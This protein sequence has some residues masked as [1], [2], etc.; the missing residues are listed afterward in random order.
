MYDTVRAHPPRQET[1]QRCWTFGI[2]HA[3]HGDSRQRLAIE[4]PALLGTASV[5][6]NLR[7][8]V[9]A[10]AY[11]DDRVVRRWFVTQAISLLD[12]VNVIRHRASVS[13]STD[14]VA[15]PGS[16]SD[17]PARAPAS[18][19]SSSYQRNGMNCTVSGSS[20]QS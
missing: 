13:R 1:V 2:E 20:A 19:T 4:R 11:D 10:A 7:H 15:L 9:R 16:R 5:L 8:R 6:K 3:E 12:A 14:N 17:T 18:T